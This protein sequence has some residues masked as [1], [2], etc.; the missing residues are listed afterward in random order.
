MS[1]IVE[2]GGMLGGMLA[3]YASSKKWSKPKIFFATSCS[4]FTLFSVYVL[5]FPSE[6]GVLV[7]ILFAICLGIVLGLFC[8]GLMHYYEKYKK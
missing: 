3:E 7:G 5:L 1:L 2:I 6:R 4:F 8:I